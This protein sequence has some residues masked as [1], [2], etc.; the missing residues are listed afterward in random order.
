M[1]YI[2]KFLPIFINYYWLFG[3]ILLFFSG[4]TTMVIFGVLAVRYPVIKFSLLFVLWVITSFISEQLLFLGPKYYKSNYEKYE[5]HWLFQKI[6]KG[7][8]ST[9]LL[10]FSVARFFPVL[11][12]L[13]PVALGFTSCSTT[14]FSWVNF[15]IAIV[16]C[17]VFSSLGIY[18]GKQTIHWQL[19]TIVE[20]IQSNYGW[21]KKLFLG[22]LLAIVVIGLLVVWYKKVHKK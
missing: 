6:I 18:I 11:R 16:W 13:A 2:L 3:P 5:N 9:G 4:E 19:E 10:L 20:N 21:F 17:G 15:L 7:K 1:N 12:I 14:V 22:F 8:V